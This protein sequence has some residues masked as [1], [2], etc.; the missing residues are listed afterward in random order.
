MRILW[1][2]HTSTATPCWEGSRHYHLLPLLQKKHEIHYVSWKRIYS[3]VKLF[4]QWGKTLR[5]KDDA[6]TRYEVLL[7]PNIPSISRRYYPKPVQ[8]IANQLFYQ[9]AVKR[10]VNTLAPDLMV[11]SSSHHFTG[12]PYFPTRIPVIFDY[13][14]LT[15]AYVLRNFVQ[16][17]Q[18]VIGIS[19]G[20]CTMV[21]Q[22]APHTHYIPNGLHLSPYQNQTKEQAK[23]QLGLH[24]YCVVSLIGLTGSA[25]LYFVDSIFEAQKTIPNLCFL[26]VG[27]GK[28]KHAIEDKAQKLGVKNLVCVGQVPYQ[29]VHPYFLATDIGIYPGDDIPYFH[30]ACPIK[31]FHY[32]AAGAQVVCSPVD[33]FQGGWPNVLMTTPNPKEF[34]QA[35]LKAHQAPKPAP[36]LSSYD[37]S[38]LAEKFNAVLSAL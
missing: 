35:I 10:L 17:S 15:A 38:M 31:I 37:W 21:E 25:S 2:T 34:A 27:S 7:G 29:D 13:L 36:T 16:H 22:N 1:L 30:L 33:M 4:N 6:G 14:D 20:L 18:H 26:T 11:V 32:S 5:S 8:V 3:P 12:F 24:G 9:K 23:Q 19:P 28:M